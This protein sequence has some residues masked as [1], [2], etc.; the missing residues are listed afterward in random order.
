MEV[1]VQIPAL[2]DWSW[3]R[4]FLSGIHFLFFGKKPSLAQ[5]TTNCP[6]CCISSG[7]LVMGSTIVQ[8]LCAFPLCP[9]PAGPKR[10]QEQLQN[11]VLGTGWGSSSLWSPCTCTILSQ[12][13]RE[14]AQLCHHNCTRAL[15]HTSALLNSSG[16]L[17]FD[18][19][20]TKRKIFMRFIKFLWGRPNH[21]PAKSCPYLQNWRFICHYRLIARAEFPVLISNIYAHNSQV[22]D[23]TIQ[24]L[25]ST[26]LADVTSK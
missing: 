16:N 17:L 9:C 2:L 20:K 18:S 8:L 12:H 26:I 5:G 19:M 22:A 23:C 1:L 25:I 21:P 11:V 6:L 7:D 24:C 3:G 10:A 14:M 13:E 15:Q 4:P